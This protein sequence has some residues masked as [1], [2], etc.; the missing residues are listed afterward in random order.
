MAEI[1]K[2]E[3]LKEG[4][5]LLSIKQFATAMKVTPQAIQYA[6]NKDKVDFIKIGEQRFILMSTK[7]REYAPYAA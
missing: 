1:D 3:V 7:T 5:E 6:I 4:I 2:K